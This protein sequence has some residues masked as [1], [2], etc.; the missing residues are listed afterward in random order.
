MRGD[1]VSALNDAGHIVYPLPEGGYGRYSIAVFVAD[2]AGT[3]AEAEERIEEISR[4][5]WNAHIMREHKQL[6]ASSSAPPSA[7]PVD[8]PR[9]SLA[10]T[11]GAIAAPFAEM[12]GEKIYKAVECYN[13]TH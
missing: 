7:R 1:T 9:V 2:Y 10:E 11:L 5:V 6:A 8:K 13:S 4:I 3:P 12:V